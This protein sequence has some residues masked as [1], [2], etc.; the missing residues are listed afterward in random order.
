MRRR[1][2]LGLLAAAALAGCAAA[3]RYTALGPDQ[4]GLVSEQCSRPNPPRHESAW[5]PAPADLEQAEADLA[6]LDALAPPETMPK[7]CRW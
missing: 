4:L 7:Y 3:P 2:E 6:Q 5:Q 1:T